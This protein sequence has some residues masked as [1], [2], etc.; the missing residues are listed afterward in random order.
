M[1]RMFISS[2]IMSMKSCGYHSGGDLLDTSNL[3]TL[4][5]PLEI[6]V[7]DVCLGPCN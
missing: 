5:F 2:G 1:G 3:M 4:G 6:P 7:L